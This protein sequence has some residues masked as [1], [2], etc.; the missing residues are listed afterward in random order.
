MKLLLW[1]ALAVVAYLIWRAVKRA[2]AIADR[3][4][5]KPAHQM[6]SCRH[7]KVY[8]PQADAVREGD[9]FYCGEEHAAAARKA[10]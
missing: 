4:P 7:C 2:R 8:L 10:R 3:P 6:V 1:V 9:D 5:A